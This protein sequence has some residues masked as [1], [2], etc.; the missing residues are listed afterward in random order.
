MQVNI[1]S[2][3]IRGESLSGEDI[4][5]SDQFQQAA[6][7]TQFILWGFTLIWILIWIYS[8]CKY[9]KETTREFTYSPGWAVIGCII[10][11]YNLVHPYQV[12]VAIWN[13]SQPGAPISYDQSRTRGTHLITGWWIISLAS[14]FSIL[15]AVI[16]QGGNVSLSQM[17]MVGMVFL[18]S[19]IINGI[20]AVL[21]I[22]LVNQVDS[23]QEKQVISYSEINRTIQL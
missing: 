18:L 15:V 9:L 13:T 6:T 1:I 17:R 8:I 4:L 5:R 19:Y 23:L 12:M 14:V 20:A 16:S 11:F 7:L 3:I 2:Q 22:L 21:T 10:P